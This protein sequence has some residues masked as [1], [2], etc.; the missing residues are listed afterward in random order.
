MKKT[1]MIFA[2][3]V[4]MAGFTTTVMAQTSASASTDA[5]TTLI[6]PM[7]ITQTAALHFGNVTLLTFRRKFFL[8]HIGS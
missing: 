8:I 7:T 1:L 3:I 6:V 2:A 5:G 4:M